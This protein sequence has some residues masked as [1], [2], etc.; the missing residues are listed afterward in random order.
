[1]AVPNIP[2]DNLR[3]SFY[4]YENCD[5]WVWDFD[6]TLIDTTTYYVNSMKEDDIKKR[7]DHELDQEIPC[8][9]YFV[10]LVIFLIGSGKHVGIASF[11]TY[12]IIQAYMDRLFGPNQKY[13]TRKN[14]Q[15]ACRYERT[16][17]YKMPRN[18]NAYIY[19]LMEIYR[20]Q[21][22]S[23]VV[24]FDDLPSN[25]ADASSIGVVAIQIKGRDQNGINNRLD[26]FCPEIMGK[27]DFN[28]NKQCG[29]NVYLN[30]KFGSVGQRKATH[31]DTQFSKVVRYMHP[32]R[33]YKAKEN[34]QD[35]K[36]EQEKQL[37]F[38]KSIS[39][40]K[41]KLPE[42]FKQIKQSNN[43]LPCSLP[44]YLNTKTIIILIMIIMML[45]IFG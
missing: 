25:I 36:N 33:I 24:L 10:K 44:T 13:F 12:E 22:Y 26:L 38:I 6:D 40:K 32:N 3:I 9:K 35:K 15:A 1:M 19:D 20:V 27:I 18:K 8:W 2:D 11:G 4:L 17:E 45:F 14:I 16:K 34:F 31:R 30:K 28:V 7:T 43:N 41:N 42:K 5:L 39:K 29:S 21:D 23:K 37:A